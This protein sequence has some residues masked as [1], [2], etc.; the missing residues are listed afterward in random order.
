MDDFSLEIMVAQRGQKDI[1]K[2]LKGKNWS[3]EILMP[4]KNMIGYRKK[5]KGIITERTRRMCQ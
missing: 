2:V 5:N 3:T 4:I 1:F